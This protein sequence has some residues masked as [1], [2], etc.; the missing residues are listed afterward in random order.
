M[1]FDFEWEGK[2]A[3]SKIGTGLGAVGFNYLVNGLTN[4]NVDSWAPTD[5]VSGV[6]DS[7]SVE[8]FT[9]ILT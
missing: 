2:K 4:S 6:Y 1:M 5:Y 8:P 7:I 3:G 9:E